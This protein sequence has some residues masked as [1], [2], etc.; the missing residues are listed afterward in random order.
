MLRKALKTL[1][2][3]FLIIIFLDTLL[4]YIIKN[5]NI[6]EA[7]IDFIKR[8]L[9]SYSYDSK[10]S[11][12]FAQP[13]EVMWFIPVLFVTKII[14]WEIN[15]VTK[16][17]EI[18]KFL[19]TILIMIFGYWL[20][21]SIDVAMF[22]IIFMYTGY[23]LKKYKLLEKLLRDYKIIL[24]MLIIWIIGIKFSRIELAVRAY[25]KADLSIITAI[26]GTIVVFKIS[27]IIRLKFKV[28]SR[29]L[30]WY[31]RNSMIILS[32]HH[33][34]YSYLY[35]LYSKISKIILNGHLDRLIVSAIKILIATWGLLFFTFLKEI[36]TYIKNIINPKK[37]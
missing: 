1:I 31:G 16:A 21:F 34:E 15:K 10:I 3:P 30:Q 8:I 26:C 22:S 32:I 28:I 20:P 2:V 13:L 12:D 33:L 18:L 29:V 7:I 14:F 35:G 24:V 23:I 17:N 37:N 6:L 27:E 9:V 25:P 5:Q 19:I 11:Y 4:E 36:F